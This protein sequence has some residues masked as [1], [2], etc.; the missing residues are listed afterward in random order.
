MIKEI[1]SHTLI[2][3]KIRYRSISS[4]LY[5]LMFFSLALLM[6]LASGG[7]FSGVS[8][9][10]GTSSR[11]LV[12]SPLTVAYFV[13]FLSV[14]NLFI[15][16]PVF[17][18]AICKDFINNI[19]Q[20]VFS[21]PLRLKNFILGRF[22]GA[23][24]FMLF[25]IS[26]IPLGIFVASSLP[27][28]LPSM[29]GPQSLSGYLLPIFTVGLTNILI[30]G[31]LFFMMGSIT[32]KMA[33]IY[34]GATVLVILWL[35]SGQML[36]DIE[37]KT[38]ATL[39]DPLGLTAIGQTIRYW[40]VHQQ[41]T[42]ALVFESYYLWNR[43]LWLGLGSLSLLFTLY[44]FSIEPKKSKKK[45][46]LSTATPE[47]SSLLKNLP[48]LN[49]AS[50]PW[51]SIF[52]KQ[53]AFDFFQTV[54]SIYFIV[55][56]LAGIGYMFV[57]GAQVGKMFGTN[58]YPVT[59]NVLGFMGGTFSLFM[60]IIITLYTGETIWRDRDLKINQ[61]IDA[62]PIPN[63]ALLAAKYFNM[64]LVTLILLTTVLITGIL[65]QM[66][67]GYFNFEIS[68]Y[69]IRLYLIEFPN[70]VNI[71]TLVFFLQIVARNKYL[72]HGLTIIYY[73]IISFASSLGFEHFLYTF[74]AG[75]NVSY[76]DM[77]GFGHLFK[78]FHLYNFYWLSLSAILFLL[79]YL[80]WQR[81]TSTL[82][83]KSMVRFGMNQ[84]TTPIK[85]AFVVFFLSFVS[86][87]SYLFYQTN[88]INQYVTQ[89]D[90]E[91]LSFKYENT[92]KKFE[93]L[94]QPDLISV[95]ANV[96]IFPEKL[97]VKSQL[98]LK[99]KNN[100]NT[101]ITEFMIHF[102]EHKN[103]FELSLSTTQTE[104]KDF[105]LVIYKLETPLQP[106]EE[107]SAEYSV[108]IDESTI[109]NGP[110]IGN[111]HYNGTFFNNFDYFPN[112]G[113]QPG[114]ELSQRKTREKF[115]LKPKPRKPSIDDATQKEFNYIGRSTTWID[116]ETIVST[117]T[118]QIAIAPGY[119]LK[120]WTENN[121]KYFH[122][123]M[124]QKI[125]NFYAFLSA[126]Y[127][128]V[129]DQWNDVKIEIY[130]HKGHEY[131]L[132]RMIKGTKKSLDYF[133][134]NFGP[135]QHK[136]FRIIEFPRYATFAQA[137]PNT[138]PF[139]EGIGFIAKV[140]DSNPKDIDYPFYITSHEMAH[141]WWAHQ[142]IGANVQGSEMLSESFSQYSALMVMEK[143]F[144]RE[145]MKKFLKYELDRYLMGRS[146]E[147]EFENPI[148]LTEAQ[149]YIHYQKA[150]L[151]FYAL[152]DYLGE[153]IVNQAIQETLN[154]YG[155]RRPPYPTSLSFIE[156]LKQKAKPDQ[157]GLIEDML[158]KIV[159]FENRPLTATA[160]KKS[161]DTYTVELKVQSTKL[162]SDKDGKETETPF[163]QEMDIG[164]QGKDD[165][166]IYLKKHLIKSGE[167]IIKIE[168]QSEPL[169]A[170]IDP[171]N[172]LIDRNSDDNLMNITIAL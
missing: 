155:T 45:T 18:Q 4:Y 115:G 145:K 119:L 135:Y 97:Q 78:I 62:L 61:I 50:R 60:L 161:D 152:K 159:L 156:I 129:Q 17:G 28:I 136:Q 157:L 63:S 160:T 70:Y 66:A 89:K 120:E 103:S 19:D 68:Q 11:A 93:N 41:N 112:M 39:L 131:N 65:T 74:G 142:L 15:I 110:N 147:A 32:K 83:F 104:D 141:Q 111:I 106:G 133:T 122:Y 7:A 80:F 38:L 2:E 113:Y 16:A 151:V 58:T 3:L 75:P 86:L 116:F 23:T 13:A 31:S 25:I 92:Y 138:I 55:I 43:L 57:V 123:K 170:G 144:G 105:D 81:G 30:F 158:E 88:I 107:F 134:K 140:D 118:D 84:L 56:V 27:V 168:V 132:E 163:S 96:D 9:S 77:N 126:R 33:P 154:K 53:L 99:Y 162:V 51:F 79:S 8:V 165:K 44:N 22:L 143:E 121:R 117:S 72:G 167:N 127:E 5:F 108:D 87:G 149:G 137:F 100:Q 102:P 114:R 82:N 59:Y 71:L 150:S 95:F 130:H 49:L 52:K 36:S 20:I 166:F 21:T 47:K 101:P 26:S 64:I 172:I 1:L 124:D 148:Y 171:L 98:K 76:S 14:F 54:K 153:D 164:V 10:F 146:Q 34:V 24:I 91:K 46:N 128:V 40:S 90:Q 67:Y 73:L 29:L 139:S 69:L 35:S 48:P 85:I 12:N 42:Q 109:S 37:N 125:L 6:A 169:K 94:N